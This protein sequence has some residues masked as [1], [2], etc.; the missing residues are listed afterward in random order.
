MSAGDLNLVE[1]AKIAMMSGNYREAERFLK[2]ALERNPEDLE[3]LLN[4][5]ILYEI[6]HNREGALE[7]LEKAL[8]LDPENPKLR[9]RFERLSNL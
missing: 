9:E 2:M 3:A 8:K 6:T 4:L 5:S 1:E 7:A